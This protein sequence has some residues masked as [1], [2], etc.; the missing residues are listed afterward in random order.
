MQVGIG[1]VDTEEDMQVGI[2]VVMGVREEVEAVVLV[3][4]G[5]AM[6][7]MVV[8]EV[9][10][11]GVLVVEVVEEEAVVSRVLGTADFRGLSVK[12]LMG[13]GLVRR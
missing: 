2:T 7:V 1:V 5:M 10:E 8:V 13:D 12:G 3:E 11:D 4:V 9:V 6:V